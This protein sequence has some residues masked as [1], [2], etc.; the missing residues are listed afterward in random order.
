VRIKR[1]PLKYN[2]ETWQYFPMDSASPQALKADN[3]IDLA[4]SLQ[5]G[6]LPD[7]M[8]GAWVMRRSALAVIRKLKSSGGLYYWQPSAAAW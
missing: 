4:N 2:A 3:L 7:E 5:D 1:A 6:Y 8:A